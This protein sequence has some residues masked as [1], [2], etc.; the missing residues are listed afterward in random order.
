MQRPRSLS[1]VIGL[2]R[3]VEEKYNL[4]QKNFM[5]CSL[6]PSSP[7]KGTSS[8][9]LLRTQPNATPPS[10]FKRLTPSEAKDR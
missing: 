6:S 10:T 7:K 8:T 3:L 9:G 4:C 5:P 2:A 1:T